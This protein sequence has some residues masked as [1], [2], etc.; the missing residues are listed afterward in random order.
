MGYYKWWLL[1]LINFRS[2]ILLRTFTAFTAAM[3]LLNNKLFGSI[4]V[5]IM[6]IVVFL[7]Q[8]VSSRASLF[9]LISG[10]RGDSFSLSFP[11]HKFDLYNLQSS[12]C[13]YL[14]FLV[15]QSAYTQERRSS[16]HFGE[17]KAMLY[18]SVWVRYWMACLKNYI[19]FSV[20]F[21][22]CSLSPGGL[23]DI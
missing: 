4:S 17:Q 7:S 15:E 1:I 9:H 3:F 14:I 13:R 19:L 23:F 16:W 18:V 21:L 22:L 6:S 8:N 10:E 5:I 12:D 11:G 2:L 20:K